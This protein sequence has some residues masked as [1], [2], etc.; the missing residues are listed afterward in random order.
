MTKSSA[1]TAPKL[2]KA[3]LATLHSE[4]PISVIKALPD[5]I[6]Y[7]EMI[8]QQ[9][10]IGS[11]L[12]LGA[13]TVKRI[14][15][16]SKPVRASLTVLAYRLDGKTPQTVVLKNEVTGGEFEMNVAKLI[17]NLDIAYRGARKKLPEQG[18]HARTK[19]KAKQRAHRDAAIV[20][21]KAAE[22][23]DALD[24]QSLRRVRYFRRLIAAQA[25]SANKLG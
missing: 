25:K 9:A 19:A 3:E 10:I 1:R 22:R 13:V 2:T 6:T 21:F 8:R 23:M 16:R 4:G 24:G 20:Y 5:P 7:E 12:A 14:P 15:L 17:N 18:D 11:G